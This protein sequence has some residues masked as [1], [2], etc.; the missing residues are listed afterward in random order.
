MF[1]MRKF[2]GFLM[3]LT[4][5]VFSLPAFAHYVTLVMSQGPGAGQ[6][7]AKITN[8]SPSGPYT[9]NSLKMPF[10]TNVGS[11]A[12]VAV[13]A[14]S[15][16]G[17]FPT[18]S[19]A[20]GNIS[21]PSGMSLAKGQSITL[22]LSGVMP[23]SPLPSCSSTSTSWT[24]KAYEDS[25]YG[26]YL[27]QLNSSG[28][29]LS[30]SFMP[31]CYTV[32]ASAGANGSV[33][34]SGTTTLAPNSSKTYT[35]TANSAYHVADVLVDGVSVGAVGSYT[36]SSVNANHTIS[37]TFAINSYTIS[38]TAGP[39]GSVTPIGS[40]TVNS[41]GSQ[42]YVITANSPNHIADVVVDGV[43]VGAVGSFTFSNVNA[44][45]TISATFAINTYSI[46]ATSGSNGSVTP[47]GAS[48][49]NSG[50]SQLYAIAASGGYYIADV[51]VDN[52]TVG[53]V[54]SYTFSNVTASHTISASF[55]RKTLSITSAPTN[56]ALG[57]PFD[58]TIG[59]NPSDSSAVVSIGSSTC[60]ASGTG[61]TSS[62]PSATL[63]VT[64]PTSATLGLCTIQFVSGDYQLAPV[65]L[66]VYHGTVGCDN[67]TNYD[68]SNGN[69]DF[70]LDPNLEGAYV[71]Y[72]GWGVRRG[73]NT[74]AS[75]C[76]KVNL[77]CSLES[78]NVASCVY[79]KAA[80]QQNA[81]LKYVVLW[82]ATKVDSSGLT[83]GWAQFRPSVSWGITNPVLDSPDYVPALSCVL[84]AVDL[85]T[86]SP[87][88]LLALLPVI[89]AVEP[90]LSSTYPQ[91]APGQVAKMCIA[92]Q[93]ATSIGVD[94]SGHILIQ[95]WDKVIDQSDG[96]VKG[97][98]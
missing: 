30:T 9:I 61:G 27:Y 56:A 72:S 54:A 41:G 22:T 70:T 85:T 18:A 68:S 21:I 12:S 77:T 86:L 55:A 59:I 98:Q 81:A 71:G 97:P 73:A 96:F 43:S 69:N 42:S 24:I 13:T 91:Y 25:N 64:I 80:S 39:N 16:R 79:D 49:V 11:V 75:A 15:P 5:A 45:H 74:D 95:F 32:T 38:A 93:G 48:T 50:G 67:D 94:D 14:Y 4:F 33:T 92:Q 58:V 7:T 90:F 84:D 34:P 10:G 1:G 88:D 65:I 36:F 53:A 62:G 44:N 19:P 17:T 82:N 28:N 29:N 66:N 46:T 2:A 31:V 78:N 60:N 51:L 26:G 8:T 76:V 47:S 6:L 20:G 87:A 89:P 63:S 57:T 40:T 23:K 35:I 37:A 83:S 3:A 52:A